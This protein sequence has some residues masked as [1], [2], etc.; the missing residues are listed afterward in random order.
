[1]DTN[2]NE[3]L[4]HEVIDELLTKKRVNRP[5]FFQALDLAHQIACDCSKLCKQLQNEN[6]ELK[7]QNNTLAW[8]VSSQANAFT[9]STKEYHA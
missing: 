9:S 7:H 8:F 4:L 1:M 5:K 6:T 2:N 3:N